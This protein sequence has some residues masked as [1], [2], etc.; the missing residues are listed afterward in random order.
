MI[1]KKKIA[2]ITFAILCMST[3]SLQADIRIGAKVG[4]NLANA[5]LSSDALQTENFTGFQ[6][7]PIAEI[8]TLSGFGADAAILFSRQGIKMKGRSNQPGY[9]SLSYES[10]YEEKANTLDIPVNLKFKFSLADQAGI[11]L[12]AGPYI[13]FKLDNQAILNKIKEDWG[14]KNFGVGLNFGAG[15]LL[16][17]NLQIGVNFQLGLND[18]YSD[19]SFISEIKN[20]SGKTR[21]WSITAA[22]FF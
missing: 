20:L 14:T 11:Y 12:S 9:S 5:T 15:V 18:D 13:S 19:F 7:G 3:L 6:I 2:M 16:L 22:Y 1:M 17:K 21:I 8:S 10:E 4:I